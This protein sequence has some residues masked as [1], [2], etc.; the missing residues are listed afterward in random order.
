MSSSDPIGLKYQMHEV[1]RRM[2]E[3]V[4]RLNSS[5]GWFD[6]ERTVGD[7]VALLHAEVSEILEAYRDYGMKDGTKPPYRAGMD[8]NTERPAKPEGVAVEM[9]DVLIRLL[10]MAKRWDIDIVSAFDEKMKY[11]WTRPYRHGRN[12]KY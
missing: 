1:F 4:F 11:N 5:K 9:A 12:V 3:E 7:M 10:D 8:P 2:E 6:E